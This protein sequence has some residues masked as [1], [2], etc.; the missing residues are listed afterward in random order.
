MNTRSLRFLRSRI[1]SRRQ[2]RGV[3]LGE[4]FGRLERSRRPASPPTRNR[5]RHWRTVLPST[6]NRSAVASGQH[7]VRVLG[8]GVGHESS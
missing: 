3:R 5:S 7:R 6:W 4:C 2:R 8:S 1:T